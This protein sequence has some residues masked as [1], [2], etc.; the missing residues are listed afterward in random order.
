MDM[1]ER[2]RERESARKMQ[3]LE[4]R[5]DD[6]NKDRTVKVGAPPRLSPPYRGGRV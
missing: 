2:E 4:L 1:E 3:V 5:E 6:A